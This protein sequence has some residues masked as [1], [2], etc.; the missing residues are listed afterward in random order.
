VLNCSSSGKWTAFDVVV[1]YIRRAAYVQDHSNPITEG[2]YMRH[3]SPSS[4]NSQTL[5]LFVDALNQARALD[6][7]FKRTGKVKGPLHGVPMSVKDLFNIA[8][9]DSCIGFSAWCDKP[10]GADA[11]IVEAVKK[12]GGIILCK[13]FLSHCSLVNNSI[14]RSLLMSRLMYHRLC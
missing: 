10:A 6:E 8:G 9:Y 12:A 2:N 13:V 14:L 4:T 3:A 5:V 1:A 11:S 7:E